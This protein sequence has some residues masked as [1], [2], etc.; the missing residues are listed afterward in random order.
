MLYLEFYLTATVWSS[1]IIFLSDK[2]TKHHQRYLLLTG[3]VMPVAAPVVC[4]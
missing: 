2:D 1:F 3:K 4:V